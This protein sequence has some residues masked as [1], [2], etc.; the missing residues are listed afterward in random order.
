MGVAAGETSICLAFSGLTTG[1]LGR[2]LGV[3]CTTCIPIFP[4]TKESFK[5]ADDEFAVTLSDFK[6][7]SAKEKASS[8]VWPSRRTTSSLRT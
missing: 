2:G 8:I 7:Q 4:Q 3:T 1:T 6:M 5:A